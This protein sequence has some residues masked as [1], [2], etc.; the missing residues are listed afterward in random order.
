VKT[1]RLTESSRSPSNAKELSQAIHRTDRGSA[2]LNRSLSEIWDSKVK[3][4][5][6]AASPVWL[7][8]YL[9]GSSPLHDQHRSS[10]SKTLPTETYSQTSTVRPLNRLA[11]TEDGLQDLCVEVKVVICRRVSD[12]G[13]PFAQTSSFH[14]P[15]LSSDPCLRRSSGWNARS[16]CADFALFPSSPRQR[17]YGITSWAR[18]ATPLDF[19]LS[20]TWTCG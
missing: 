20:A 3:N 13:G 14:S 19:I 6:S 1:S 2:S 7:L 5:L 9:D 17:M 10:S 11:Q 18:T 12:R 16:A 4:C 8:E 15:I